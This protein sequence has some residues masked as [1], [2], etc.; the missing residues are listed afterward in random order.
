MTGE[1]L[2]EVRGGGGAKE[3]D[4]WNRDGEIQCERQRARKKGRQLRRWKTQCHLGQETRRCH[5][6]NYIPRL[7][8]PRPLKHQVIFSLQRRVATRRGREWERSSES[9]ED[10]TA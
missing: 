8:P 9:D 1:I 10:N 4:G 7:R 2:E 3:K 6:S 5:S